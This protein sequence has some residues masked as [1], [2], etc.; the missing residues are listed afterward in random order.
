MAYRPSTAGAMALRL[1]ERPLSSRSSAGASDG[2]R[3]AVLA[4]AALLAAYLATR[5]LFVARFPYFLDEGTYAVF[6]YEGSKSLGGLYS[7]YSIGREPLMFWLGIP[8]VK[9]GFNPLDA[10]RLVSVVVRSPHRRWWWDSMA[11]RLGGNAAGWTAAALCVVL[12]FF[13]VHDG[14]GI[15]E[16]LVTLVVAAALYLQVEFARRPDL[17]VAALLGV[18]LAAG[19]LTKENTR[20][21][22]LLLPVS[23][24]CFDWAAADRGRRL[25]TWFAGVGICVLMLGAAVLV[26]HASSRYGEFEASRESPLLYTVRSLSEVWSDPFDIGDTWSAYHPA[27]TG[28]VTIPLLAAAAAGAVLA[29]RRD[30]PLGVLLLIWVLFPFAISML[31]ST[32]PFPRHVMYLLPPVVV[33]MAYGITEGVRAILRALPGP[34][35]VALAALGVTLLLAP[36][37]RLDARVLAHPDTARYPGLDDLQYVTGTGGRHRVAPHGADDRAPG[38]GRPRDPDRP[39]GLHPGAGDAAR[40]EPALRVRLGQVAAGPPGP[41]RHHRRDP[42]L[43]PGSGRR[44]ARGEVRA[45][46]ALPPAARWRRG[47]PARAPQAVA[48]AESRGGASAAAASILRRRL[49]PTTRAAANPSNDTKLT[50]QPTRQLNGS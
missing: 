5:I 35:G 32:A 25:R 3:L 8:W 36:A 42:V 1:L 34:R 12:P 18:V 15:I 33:L 47:H 30:P 27:F 26:L 43:R 21:A 17:R 46:R 14:I 39:A 45:H 41:V 24:I 16:P 50:I 38:A 49:V 44:D 37:L 11:R 19:L 20:P 22:I 2:A 29:I 23:L 10:V 31:F 6:S 4:G 28:Y 13:L 7:S 40:A 48:G 9:L